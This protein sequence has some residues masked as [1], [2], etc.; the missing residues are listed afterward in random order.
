MTAARDTETS[1]LVRDAGAA[2]LPA[3]AAIY[4]HHVTTGFGSFEEAAPDL[5]EIARRRRD[6]V[7]LGLPYL[8][9][10]V[11][12]AIL[13]FAYAAPYRTRSAYR[14]SV[15]DSVYVDPGATG[16]GIGRALLGRVIALCTE[17]GYRQMIAVIGDS[18]NRASIRLHAS[19]GFA[20]IGALPAVGFKQGRWVDSV[21]M[22]RA[23][24]DGAD[25]LPIDRGRS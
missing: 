19:L 21:L 15:E 25:T 18:A 13:G 10:E 24:G 11:D 9:A 17:A 2:D 8:A 7:A 14:H 23:L 20:A 4:R 16:R 6:T 22:Q 5:E 1:I 12:G 3:I